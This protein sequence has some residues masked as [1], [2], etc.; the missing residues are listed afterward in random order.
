MSISHIE[1]NRTPELDKVLGS[2][3]GISI[4]NNRSVYMNAIGNKKGKTVNVWINVRDHQLLYPLARCLDRRYGYLPWILR[5]EISDMPKDPV[6]YHLQSKNINIKALDDAKILAKE[7]QHILDS[8]NILSNFSLDKKFEE[9]N[10]IDIV[11]NRE[12]ILNKIL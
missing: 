4:S 10:R 6:L 3:P 2:I 9:Q 7:I 12:N 1:N 11:E 5:V 8:G